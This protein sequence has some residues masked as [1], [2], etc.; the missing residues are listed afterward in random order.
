MDDRPRAQRTVR[1]VGPSSRRIMCDMSAESVYR[2]L[3]VSEHSV[4]SH[5]VVIVK[6][7]EDVT[8]SLSVLLTDTTHL[9]SLYHLADDVLRSRAMRG[10]E[11]SSRC[12]R[13]FCMSL[14]WWRCP[15]RFRPRPSM[16]M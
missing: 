14:D 3:S 10:R 5:R 4:V 6:Q 11:R 8:A 13:E 15:R 7:G 1:L 16:S 12:S 2:D 9:R